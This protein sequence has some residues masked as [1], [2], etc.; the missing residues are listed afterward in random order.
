MGQAEMAE[1]NETFARGTLKAACAGH[2]GRL[3]IDRP[4]KKNALDAAMWSVLPR[5]LGWLTAEGRARVIL[6]EG[7]GSDFSAGADISEFD[8]VR[9]DPPSA[10]AYDALNAQAFRAVRECEVPVIAVIRGI[11]FGG[12]FGIAAACDIRLAS[13]EA[14][15][16]VP[17][18]R[19]GLTYP[20]DAI[21][22]FVEALDVQTAK[23]LLYT[24]AEMTASEALARGFLAA[25]HEPDELVQE[26]AKLAMA[27][28]ANAPLT[29]S[30]SKVALRA[31][32][33]GRSTDRDRAVALAAATFE[34]EDYAEGRAAFAERRRPGFT[35]H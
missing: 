26:A 20:V 9:H 10:R 32:L 6:I 18:A 8:R 35:G 22:D 17:A 3:T 28:A 31:A 15:F 19:L 14:R 34:S 25:V 11:C 33:S 2:V 24:G 12:G 13:A 27:I 4:E 1:Q 5:A 7:G 16:A 29:V 30:A 21:V 23:R